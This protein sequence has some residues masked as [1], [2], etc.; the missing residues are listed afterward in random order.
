[1]PLP[2]PRGRA[3]TRRGKKFLESKEPKIIED[4]KRA[5]FLKGHS[6]SQVINDVLSDL[7]LTKK[8]DAQ[9]FSHKNDVLPFEDPSKLE[10]FSD[11]NEC[12]LV[13]LGNSTKKRPHNLTI[14]RMFNYSLLDLVEFGVLEHTP[15][16]EFNHHCALGSKPLIN[17][18]GEQWNFDPKYQK[19]AN[20]FMD[21]YH[22]EPVS[23]VN[24]A[25]F[26]RVF[27][28]HLVSDVLTM[29]HYGV[30]LKK[31]GTPLPEVELKEIGPRLK[32]SIRRTQFATGDVV[33][34]AYKVPKEAVK[35]MSKNFEKDDL[36]NIRGRV[37]MEYQDFDE[38]D[39]TAARMFKKIGKGD[40]SE[41]EEVEVEE[42]EVEEGSDVEEISEEEVSGSESN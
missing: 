28:F 23:Q 1:M 20:L 30:L 31:S 25:S 18:I 5:L 3:T 13:V 19:I 4:A 41:G 39:L 17:F 16:S 32:L 6:T 14:G 40:D 37:H 10:Y 22:G 12:P 2:K 34:A 11:R 7:Y 21:F 36:G 26:D 27:V 15:I 29:F 24:L 42:V 9:M 35:T 38:L 8:P 33:K